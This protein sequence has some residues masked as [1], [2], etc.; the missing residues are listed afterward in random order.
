MVESRWW[1]TRPISPVV[2]SMSYSVR[3]PSRRMG[4]VQPPSPESCRRM[5]GRL[6]F[7]ASL[8]SSG[9]GG[10]VVRVKMAVSF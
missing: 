4:W 1:R 2:V 10:G 7:S 8:A 3:W 6:P 5:P 9:S